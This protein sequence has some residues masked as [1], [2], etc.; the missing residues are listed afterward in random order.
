MS[1]I[2]SLDEYLSLAIGKITSPCLEIILLPFALAFNR[3]HIIIT[4]TAILILACLYADVILDSYEAA[5]A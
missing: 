3:F 4:N 1:S 5:G 2:R